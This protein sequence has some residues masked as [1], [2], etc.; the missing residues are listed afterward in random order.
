MTAPVTPATP[1]PV[2]LTV[3]ENPTGGYSA[4]NIPPVPRVP[5]T[6]PPVVGGVPA[7]VAPV[8]PVTAPASAVIQAG[9]GVPPELVGKTLDDA[10]KIYG[11]LRQSYLQTV[12]GPRTGQPASAPAPAAPAAPQAPATDADFWKNPKAAIA[13]LIQDALQQSQVPQMIQQAEAQVASLPHYAQ[14]Q[15]EIH[16]TL[17]GL[18]P[19]VV[20]DPST[21]TQA[22]DMVLGNAVRSGRLSSAQAAAPATV[23]QAP[24]VQPQRALGAQPLPAFSEAPTGSSVAGGVQLSVAEVQAAGR[25]GMSVEQYAAWKGGV[26]SGR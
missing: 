4:A 23:Q 22:Y 19:Q 2:P 12:T 1:T 26:S 16:Q 14:F 25:M 13:G 6:T 21:W 11:G 8:A 3:S 24:A 9:P 5:G 17:R 18:P 15:T 20:A 7:P 10:F